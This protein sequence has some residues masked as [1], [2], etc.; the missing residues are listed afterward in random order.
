MHTTRSK[1]PLQ[2]DEEHRF[3]SRH[4]EVRGERELQP[5]GYA[6][7]ISR[8]KKSSQGMRKTT[9]QELKLGNLKVFQVRSLF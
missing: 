5:F 1:G 6:T 2:I 4:P 7:D 9:T 8:K 3:G